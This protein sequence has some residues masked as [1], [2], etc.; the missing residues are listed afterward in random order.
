[1]SEIMF[2]KNGMTVRVS[3]EENCSDVKSS[4]TETIITA[5][6]IQIGGR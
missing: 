4:N 1:M 6:E 2:S 5:A 3:D